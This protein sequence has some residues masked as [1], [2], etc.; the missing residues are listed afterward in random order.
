MN[1]FLSFL[2]RGAYNKEQQRHVYTPT[3]YRLDRGD[4]STGENKA[5]IS[6]ETPYVQA[7]EI[8][9]LGGH[10]YDKVVIVMTPTS[11]REQFDGLLQSLQGRGA[12]SVLPMII[13][14]DSY[15]AQAQ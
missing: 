1:I 14:E 4:R 15:S 7:A 9:L 11:R 3:R 10:N 2:G 12:K 13:D 6:Q 5:E 8:E